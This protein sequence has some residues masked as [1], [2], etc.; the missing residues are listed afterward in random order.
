MTWPATLAPVDGS[1]IPLCVIRITLSHF[2][3]C[4]R[5]VLYNSTWSEVVGSKHFFFLPAFHVPYAAVPIM[6]TVLMM[7]LES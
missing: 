7:G 2:L 3:V 6:G 1:V 5:N 4:S